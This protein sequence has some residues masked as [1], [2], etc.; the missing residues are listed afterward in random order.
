MKCKKCGQH[1]QSS[2]QFLI[3]APEDVGSGPA[4]WY[5]PS[6]VDQGGKSSK[7]FRHET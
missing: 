3:W 5:V 4:G 7:A 6:E 2:G 1:I